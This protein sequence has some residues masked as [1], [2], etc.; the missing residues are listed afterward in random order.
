MRLGAG[1]ASTLPTY[2]EVYLSES[3]NG[4]F[5]VGRAFLFFTHPSVS[6]F[7]LF[8]GVSVKPRVRFAFSVGLDVELLE[9]DI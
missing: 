3:I 8:L 9:S 5:P 6:A 4:F 1:F 7:E 2:F